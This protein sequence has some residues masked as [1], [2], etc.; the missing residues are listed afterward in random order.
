MLLYLSGIEISCSMAEKVA[1]DQGA[2]EHQGRR[3]LFSLF[4]KR[5]ED[6]VGRN[7]DEMMQ[8]PPA[9][10]NKTQNPSQKMQ[11]LVDKIKQ[12]LPGRRNN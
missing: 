4:S 11:G 6:K 1:S 10:H 5:K 7:D 12:K 2:P 8:H 9:T 3:S